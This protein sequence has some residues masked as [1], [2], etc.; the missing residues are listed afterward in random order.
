MHILYS[1]ATEPEPT[2]QASTVSPRVI[3]AALHASSETTD[4]QFDDE[5]YHGLHSGDEFDSFEQ[6]VHVD[7]ACQLMV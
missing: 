3:M 7:S 4:S 1:Q 6:K 2:R 5:S